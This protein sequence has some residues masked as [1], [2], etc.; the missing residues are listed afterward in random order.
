M[1]TNLELFVTKKPYRGEVETILKNLS[2]DFR[3]ENEKWIF[4]DVYSEERWCVLSVS[5]SENHAW[6]LIKTS[7]RSDLFEK[8]MAISSL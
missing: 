5:T 1:S 3:F 6:C 4:S 2:F 8:S 7:R